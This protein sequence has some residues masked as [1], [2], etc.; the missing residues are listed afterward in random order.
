M[1]FLKVALNSQK[2]TRESSPSKGGQGGGGGREDTTMKQRMS[3]CFATSCTLKV[4]FGREGGFQPTAL[5]EDRRGAAAAESSGLVALASNANVLEHLLTFLGADDILCLSNSSTKMLQSCANDELW[6]A[7]CLSKFGVAGETSLRTSGLSCFRSL[8]AVLHALVPQ[9]GV[10]CTLEDYP[11]GT[12]VKLRLDMEHVPFRFV[13]ENLLPGQD[14]VHARL[15][16]VRACED[17]TV[18]PPRITLTTN[19]FHHHDPGFQAGR[20]RGKVAELRRVLRP[21][22]SIP[23]VGVFA[24]H[25]R[26]CSQLV[27]GPGTDVLEVVWGKREQ[28]TG[29]WWGED[30]E[31]DE[32]ACMATSQSHE[33]ASVSCAPCARLRDALQMGATLHH[34]LETMASVVTLW[35]LPCLF[36]A[37]SNR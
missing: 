19:C 30:E 12:I 10:Y 8:Y 18:S 3:Q 36:V 35:R 17:W 13:A 29:T 37:E 33:L 1:M 4:P 14:R 7:L 5:G 28:L 9:Q 15:F 11:Y 27:L 22:A 32:G 31:E 2:I 25:V 34:R 24:R 26:C 20:V 23:A 21:G 6:G 16:D